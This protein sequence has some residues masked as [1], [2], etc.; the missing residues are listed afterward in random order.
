MPLVVI[1]I[2]AAIYLT[3]MVVSPLHLQ[4]QLSTTFSR[5]TLHFFPLAMLVMAE[6]ACCSG[7][8]AN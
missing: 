2:V 5:L 6:Q 3:T 8:C 7:R 1:G 4:Y